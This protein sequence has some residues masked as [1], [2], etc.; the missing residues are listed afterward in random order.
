[1]ASSSIIETSRR[2]F[3]AH[4]GGSEAER[5]LKE[6]AVDGLFLVRPSKSNPQDCSLS[7]LRGSTVTH[8]KIQNTGDYYDLYGG[9]QFASLAELVKYYSEN[10]GELKEKGGGLI[11]LKEP[12]LSED[13]ATERWYHGGLG[14]KAAEKMLADVGEEGAFLVRASNSKPGDFV[15]S[16]RTGSE[17]RITHVMIRNRGGKFDVGGGEKFG[18]LT[19]LVDHYRT[20]PMV[21]TSGN[22]VTMDKPCNATQM[23]VLA[24]PKRVLELDRETDPVYGKTGFWEEFEQLQTMELQHGIYDRTEGQREQ[25]KKK[26]RYKNILPYNYTRVVLQEVDKKVTGSDYMNANY[27]TGEAKGP[28][29]SYI[30]CQGPLKAT[31]PAFWQMMWE[32]N[33]RVI[34]MTT[35][36]IE[37]GKNKCE[38]YW[39]R[40]G[41]SMTYGKY[42]VHVATEKEE[43]DYIL[44]DMTLKKAGDAEPARQIVMYHFKS[45]PDYGVPSNVGTVLR[46]LAL[47]NGDLDR[48]RST[49][50]KALGDVVVHCS[51]GIGRTG[52]FIIID[53]LIKMIQQNGL[54]TPIDIQRSIHRLRSMRS[55]MIQTEGQYRFVYQAMAAHITH[56]Q[57]SKTG[58]PSTLYS[59]GGGAA[60]PPIPSKGR[61]GALAL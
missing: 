56:M 24:I 18:S 57:A 26:N 14:G 32:N 17:G 29:N 50:G 9:D 60:P 34:V 31:V 47:V 43:A 51:A 23:S 53:I 5:L 42:T 20:N 11:E 3:H 36:V 44:R 40:T 25:N 52:T 2:W 33:N 15:L 58:A 10:T 48:M 19:E 46:F 59:S 21:E 35:A 6:K 13:P 39:A 4:L 38:P 1:M 30:A 45:W 37:R 7:V 22:V 8:I 49:L 12:L 54:D 27:L 41:D 61:G 16:V 55:G 28:G